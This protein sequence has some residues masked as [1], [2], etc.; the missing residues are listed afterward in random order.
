M[1]PPR[2]EADSANDTS[3]LTDRWYRTRYQFYAP[4]YRF[5]ARPLEK[6]RRRAI[7]RIAPTPGERILILGSGP[8]MDLPHL[9]RESSITALDAA[10]AMVR[11]TRDRAR[12]LG[13]DVDAQVGDAR[14]LPYE[15]DSFDVVLLHL[16]LTVVPDPRTVAKEAERVLKPSGRISIYDKFI[17]DNTKPSFLRRVLNPVTR[18]FFSDITESLEPIFAETNLEIGER[19]TAL[20]GLYT[21]TSARPRRDS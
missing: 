17:P 9:P 3:T 16:I 12:E 5:A 7:E 6:G 19:E 4:L 1:A 18:F 2:K 15:S 20:G 13:M 11:R 21:I 10:P 8:G 14:N